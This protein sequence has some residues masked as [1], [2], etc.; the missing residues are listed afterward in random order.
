MKIALICNSSWQFNRVYTD[1]ILNK[2]RSLGEVSELLNE[3]DLENNI[4]YLNECEAIF[5]TW[6]FPVLDGPH[7]DKYFKKLK[8]VFYAAG[9]VQFFARPYLERGIRV[10]SAYRA[11]AVP[12]AEYA[13]AQ[14]SLAL[15]GFFNGIRY[16]REDRIKAVNSCGE[17][18]GCYDAVVGLAGLGAIGTMVA[19]KLKQLN[20]KVLAYDPF[21]DREKA[22]RLNVELVTLEEL[23]RKSNVISNHLANKTELNDIFNISLFGLMKKNAVFINTGR[24][25]Q[26]K[27]DDLAGFL[28]ANPDKVFL[29]DVSQHEGDPENSP[30]YD[31][32]NVI[33]T[34]HIAGSSGN[35]VHRMAEY[36]MTDFLKVR[37]GESTPDEV[38][39][40]MLRTMA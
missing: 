6:D 19:E 3:D 21:A 7:I 36:M 17:F 2:I 10:F 35:E 20:V 18:P 28:K 38:T 5:T 39:S 34:P 4:G 25:A 33:F 14:I 27:E 40:D 30:L 26:V 9:S 23:F 31:C 22:E 24:G 15:K 16:Y 32:S 1:E 13:F 29:A 8:Y 12:V 11:N 37:N